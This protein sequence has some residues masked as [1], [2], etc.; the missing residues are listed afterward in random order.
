MLQEKYPFW[1]YRIPSFIMEFD[2]NK[3]DCPKGM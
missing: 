2:R 3:T 1:K